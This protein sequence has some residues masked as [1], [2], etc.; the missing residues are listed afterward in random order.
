MNLDRMST[1][2]TNIEGSL[3]KLKIK[4]ELVTLELVSITLIDFTE[5]LVCLRERERE[6]CVCVWCRAYKNNL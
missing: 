5:I 1:H 4:F 2:F 6:R 3:H